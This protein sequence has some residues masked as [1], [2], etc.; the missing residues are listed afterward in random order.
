MRTRTSA[1]I[2]QPTM[3][4][5]LQVLRPKTGV[6]ILCV[7]IY[8]AGVTLLGLHLPFGISDRCRIWI[9]STYAILGALWLV[10]VFTTRIVLT[11]ESIRIISHFDFRSRTVPRVEIDSVTWEKG[12]GASIRLRCGSWVTLP[13]IGGNAL[14]LT[15]TIRAWLK[16]TA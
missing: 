1:L 5:D 13:N 16:R 9:V 8:L 12:C 3:S 6:R 4:Q 2:R 14:D 10:D 15:N 7:V 11:T